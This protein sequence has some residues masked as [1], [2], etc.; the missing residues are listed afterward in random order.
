MVRS[1]YTLVSVQRG[2]LR[3]PFSISGRTQKPKCILCFAPRFNGSIDS[4]E[5]PNIPAADI[6]SDL[7]T[8]PN[9]HASVPALIVVPQTSVSLVSVLA[10]VAQ[11]DRAVVCS[12]S[13]YVVYLAGWVDLVQQFPDYAMRF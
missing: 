13:V 7:A 11:V 8:R 5:H 2:R 1:N 3:P 4:R 12:V 10:Y 9:V 6:R